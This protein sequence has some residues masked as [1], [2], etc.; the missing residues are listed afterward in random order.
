MRSTDLLNVAYFAPVTYHAFFGKRPPGEEEG[1]IKEAPLA[2]VIPLLIA[3][4]ISVFI[5]IFPN[6]MMDFVHAVIR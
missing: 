3:A 5:G 6:F 4:L 2:M 1:G